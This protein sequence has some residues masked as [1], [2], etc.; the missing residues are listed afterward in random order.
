[1]L[2]VSQQLN[3]AFPHQLSMQ[4]PNLDIYYW[5]KSVIHLQS[6]QQT[7]NQKKLNHTYFY[8]L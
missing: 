1:M 5:N 7:Q 2:T 4:N 3:P 8:W 6:Q